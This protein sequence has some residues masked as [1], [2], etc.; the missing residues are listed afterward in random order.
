MKV[1]LI[2]VEAEI[3][4]NDLPA[5]IGRHHTA[6]VCLD[7]AGTGEFQCIIERDDGR[8]SIRDIAGGL[9][10]FVNDRRVRMTALMPGDRLRVGRSN[11][12]VQ[13][14]LEK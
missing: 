3:V 4:L 13:Y 5:M 11:F 7:N 12:T 9:G 14:E 10:T 1:K 6:D 8:L 2:G